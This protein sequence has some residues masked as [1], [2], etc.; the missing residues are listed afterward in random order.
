MEWVA[1]T[2]HITSEHGVSSVTTADAHTSA[3]SSRL[4]LTPPAD[5]WTCP[6]RRETKYGFCA[7]AVTFQLASLPALWD[8]PL[9]LS[10]GRTTNFYAADEGG[11][12]IWNSLDCLPSY[13]RHI[14][15]NP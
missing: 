1:G 7:C 15:L 12:F 13:T 10:H 2:F 9:P 8:G 3:A 5:I 4:E 6:F 11:G 14:H